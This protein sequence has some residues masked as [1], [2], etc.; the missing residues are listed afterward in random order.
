MLA[1]NAR[2]TGKGKARMKKQN[3]W[4]CQNNLTSIIKKSWLIFVK[5]IEIPRAK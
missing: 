3:S 2:P 4:R 5:N 1:K